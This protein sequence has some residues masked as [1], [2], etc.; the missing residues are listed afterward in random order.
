MCTVHLR[1]DAHHTS[2]VNRVDNVGVVVY[3][4][5]VE[6][7]THDKETTMTVRPWYQRNY[8]RITHGEIPLPALEITMLRWHGKRGNRFA[9]EGPYTI[10]EYRLHKIG[11]SAEIRYRVE[12]GGGYSQHEGSIVEGL[13]AAEML[14]LVGCDDP[15]ATTGIPTTA[16]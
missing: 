14:E 5:V 1:P 3:I 7:T 12:T 2:F 8:S 6:P 9:V 11:R 4:E 15:P 13:T 10:H 16:H